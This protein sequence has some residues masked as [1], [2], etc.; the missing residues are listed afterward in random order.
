MPGDVDLV[1]IG[2]R[3]AANH[4]PSIAGAIDGANDWSLAYDYDQYL[5]YPVSM[6]M[7][8]SV[9]GQSSPPINVL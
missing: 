6:D 3:V 7:V 9:V 1:D 5:T 8:M 2:S 4:S